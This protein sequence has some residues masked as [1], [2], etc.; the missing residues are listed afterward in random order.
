MD[1][2]AYLS[3]LTSIV[4]ALGITRV[5]TG[6]GKLLQARG[7]VRVYWVHLVLVLNIVAARTRSERFHRFFAIFFLV[8]LLT[9]IGINLRLLT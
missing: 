1:P 8:Y 5:L 9:F 3:V 2:F 4:L 6:L 7:R